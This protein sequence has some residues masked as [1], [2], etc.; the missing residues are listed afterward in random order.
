MNTTNDQSFRILEQFTKRHANTVDHNG[1]WYGVIQGPV[2]AYDVFA[3]AGE[4]E[5]GFREVLSSLAGNTS[6][7]AENAALREAALELVHASMNAFGS[8]QAMHRL[9]D[10]RAQVLSLAKQGQQE[11]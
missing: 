2:F 1:E 5:D 4:T 3:P 11:S 8:E 7:K 6:L 9:Y 10:A